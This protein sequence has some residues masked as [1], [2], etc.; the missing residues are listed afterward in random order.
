MLAGVLTGRWLA[1]AHS[2]S[3]HTLWMLAAGVLCVA[4]GMVLDTTLMA[5]ASPE[6]SSERA[7]AEVLL[8]RLSPR[9]ARPLP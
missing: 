6:V 3:V 4:L 7:T 8:P 5:L 1:S 2:R 9:L